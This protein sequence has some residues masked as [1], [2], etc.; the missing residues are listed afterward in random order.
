MSISFGIDY[1]EFDVRAI[2]QFSNAAK[3]VRCIAPIN[4]KSV[5]KLNNEVSISGT[6]EH[7]DTPSGVFSRI[8]VTRVERVTN[9]FLLSGAL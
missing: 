6:V 9:E 7:E 8:R 4:F 1:V 2:G 3:R 5:I